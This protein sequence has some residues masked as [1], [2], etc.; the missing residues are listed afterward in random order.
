MVTEASELLAV[1][2]FRM[3]YDSRFP[4][5]M[6]RYLQDTQWASE[7]TSDRTSV[8]ERCGYFQHLIYIFNFLILVFLFLIQIE[9]VSRSDFDH[10]M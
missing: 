3:E 9:H 2:N 7:M 1:Y 4:P 8:P 6:G 5:N 10:F